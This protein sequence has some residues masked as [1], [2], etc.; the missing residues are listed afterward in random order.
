M[1]LRGEVG[2]SLAGPTEHLG[3]ASRRLVRFVGSGVVTTTSGSSHLQSPTP[4]CLQRGADHTFGKLTQPAA[5]SLCLTL[6][7]IK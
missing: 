4:E 6:A 2:K 1:C 3:D 7:A 5:G